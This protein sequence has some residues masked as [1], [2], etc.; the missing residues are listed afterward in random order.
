MGFVIIPFRLHIIGLV[1]VV[2]LITGLLNIYFGL[3]PGKNKLKLEIAMSSL[4]WDVVISRL[5]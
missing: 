2:S 4:P 5:L 3:L 1:C